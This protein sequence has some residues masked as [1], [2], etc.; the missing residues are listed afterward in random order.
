MQG[1]MWRAISASLSSEPHHGGGE[2]SLLAG[3]EGSR[4][5]PVQGDHAGHLKNSRKIAA[6]VEF[7]NKD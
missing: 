4:C 1:M 6:Q 5:V 3:P 2:R 7:E